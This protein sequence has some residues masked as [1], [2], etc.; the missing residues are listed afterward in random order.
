VSVRARRARGPDS[1]LVFALVLIGALGLLVKALY[2]YA[3]HLQ[4]MSTALPVAGAKAGPSEAPA[5]TTRP[6]PESTPPPMPAPEDIAALSSRNP[7]AQFAAAERLRRSAMTPELESA[8]RGCLPATPQVDAKLNCLRARLPGQAAIDWTVA[9]LA[10]HDAVW[11]SEVDECVCLLEA[12]ADRVNES[13]EPIA[14]AVFPFA[15]S[16]IARPREPALRALASARLT[17]VP[18]AIRSQ[19]DNAWHHQLAVRAALTL[20]MSHLDPYAVEQWL[21]DSD[22][23]QRA[24]SRSAVIESKD[25]ASARVLVRSLL[26]HPEDTDL[27]RCFSERDR[28]HQDASAEL[29]GVALDESEPQGS[30]QRALEVLGT[31][32]SRQSASLLAPLL[33]HPDQGLRAYAEAAAAGLEKR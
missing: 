30:R 29:V 4:R 23:D 1:R 16:Y 33:R 32:G 7:S 31:L 5:L 24:R 19:I 3:D 11:S 10:N 26:E 15:M 21:F 20:G 14:Q 12:L 22:P 9:R 8:I 25:P 18:P 6:A 2:W 27:V 13:P 28:R 17:S